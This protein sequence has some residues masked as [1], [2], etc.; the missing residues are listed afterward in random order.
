MKEWRAPTTPDERDV[1]RRI[2]EKGRRDNTRLI[3]EIAA[4][5]PEQEYLDFLLRK[6]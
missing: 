6:L 3:A 1:L 5:L 2:D 4:E